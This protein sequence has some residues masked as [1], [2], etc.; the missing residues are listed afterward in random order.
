METGSLE[1]LLKWSDPFRHHGPAQ[2]NTVNRTRHDNYTK[3][4]SHPV[5]CTTAGGTAASHS[6]TSTNLSQHTSGLSPP[7]DTHQLCTHTHT[8]LGCNSVFPPLME[9][10]TG[11]CPPFTSPSNTQAEGTLLVVSSFSFLTSQGCTFPSDTLPCTLYRSEKTGAAT[12][13][14]VQGSE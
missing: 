1:A 3:H 14:R 12:P 10:V 5:Q 13:Q 9:R 11:L 8:H 4:P 2:H 7:G 6:T